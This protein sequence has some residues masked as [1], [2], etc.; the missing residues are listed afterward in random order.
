MLG[1]ILLESLKPHGR[2]KTCDCEKHFIL[3][4]LKKERKL[5]CMYQK[6]QRHVWM[7][8]PGKQRTC[9]HRKCCRGIL[10]QLGDR[11][12]TFDIL[13]HNSPWLN[14][15]CSGGLWNGNDR[16]SEVISVS[17]P[18]S[19][20]LTGDDKKGLPFI[21][22]SDP[23]PRYLYMKIQWAYSS[24]SAL[25]IVFNCVDVRFFFLKDAFDIHSTES[26]LDTKRGK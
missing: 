3:F 24:E 19:G 10:C 7:V 26:V 4:Q 11:E 23:H 5:V 17:C 8:F 2:I 20:S 14:Y 25:Y 15:P 22:D 12:E 21:C 9:L 1:P 6:L 13:S 16:M 18:I